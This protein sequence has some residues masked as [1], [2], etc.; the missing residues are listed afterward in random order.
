MSLIPLSFKMLLGI[1]LVV[2]TLSNNGYDSA[3]DAI[4]FTVLL[5]IK[6]ASE[7]VPNEICCLCCHWFLKK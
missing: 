5:L 1:F 7:S 2:N 3:I 6:T 4:E